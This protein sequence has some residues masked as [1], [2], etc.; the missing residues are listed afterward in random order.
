MNLLDFI[1]YAPFLKKLSAP[2]VMARSELFVE[3]PEP[4][5]SQYTLAL[6]LTINNVLPVERNH[7]LI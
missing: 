7:T 3:R 6:C 4:S 2:A 5:I 1:V